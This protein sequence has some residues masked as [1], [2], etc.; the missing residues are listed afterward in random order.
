MGL[1]TFDYGS[2]VVRVTIVAAFKKKKL[3]CKAFE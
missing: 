2:D 1:W 3:G